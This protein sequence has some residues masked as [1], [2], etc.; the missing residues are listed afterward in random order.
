M[1]TL[2]PMHAIVAGALLMAP[3]GCLDVPAYQCDSDLNC[4]ADGKSGRCL[5]LSR[6]CVYP[7]ASCGDTGWENAAGDCV[8]G[9]TTG[10]DGAAA[11]SDDGPSATDSGTPSPST[12]TDPTTGADTMAV[13]DTGPGE[14]TTT[15]EPPPGTTTGRPQGCTGPMDDITAMGVVEADTVFDDNYQPYLSVDGSFASSWFSSGPEGGDTPSLY[16]W[17]VLSP[18]CIAQINITGNGLHSNPSFRE[19]FGFGSVVIRVFDEADD[20]V[21][22][23]MFGLAGTPDPPVVAFPNVEGVRVELELA[24]HEN[25]SCGGFSELE[26]VGN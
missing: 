2:T 22:Q 26:L 3:W 17:S 18:V 15:D 21:F 16:T 8:A 4:V 25:S 7:S 5:P 9:P 24:N 14:G 23:Q 10:D 19:G 13:E 1:R 12:S 11:S 20:V 6:T